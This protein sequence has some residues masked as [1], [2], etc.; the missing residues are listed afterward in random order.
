MPHAYQPA[1]RKHTFGIGA[2]TLQVCASLFLDAESPSH[3]PGRFVNN[4]EGTHL[5]P[6]CRFGSGRSVYWH[7]EHERWYVNIFAIGDHRKGTEMLI[8]Y[9]TQKCM[10]TP[11]P[12]PFHK[13][14]TR[15]PVIM[16]GSE[17][18]YGVCGPLGLVDHI[19][20]HVPMDQRLPSPHDERL[21]KAIREYLSPGIKKSKRCW[22][23]P[24]Y[25]DGVL[26]RH[27]DTAQDIFVNL[28]KALE[29]NIIVCDKHERTTHILWD[30]DTSYR[31][32]AVS[33]P[34]RPA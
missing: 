29:V 6:N 28:A 19:Y 23:S 1:L 21:D 34:W 12:L 2:Y 24:V 7:K 20:S 8:D 11:L 22:R 4:S 16:D 30:E 3:F 25:K 15:H 31:T 32:F 33:Y 9:R 26:V 5:P 10:E 17:W 18:W 27:G 13:A 14:M